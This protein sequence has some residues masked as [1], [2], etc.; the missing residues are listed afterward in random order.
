MRESEKNGENI[1]LLRERINLLVTCFYDNGCDMG[2]I[3][4]K[5][6]EDDEFDD[7]ERSKNEITNY[8]GPN[9]INP[10]F[11][12]PVQLELPFVERTIN[13]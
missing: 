8:I 5:P 3:Y 12:S 2:Y 6:P 11:E 9:Q 1:K 13:W 10:N 7:Y 4:L